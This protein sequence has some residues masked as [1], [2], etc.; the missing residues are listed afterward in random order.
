MKARHRPEDAWPL[1][2]L[3]TS[4][5]AQHRRSAASGFST[6]ATLHK[7][8]SE[9]RKGRHSSAISPAEIPDRLRDNS[10]VWMTPQELTRN[11]A[12]EEPI[13]HIHKLGSF[14]RS[15]NSMTSLSKDACDI[16]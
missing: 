4:F 13:F 12:A 1:H 2:R 6:R 16:E 5:C 8:V 3:Q 7:R 15:R 9:Y 14:K 10:A 11:N